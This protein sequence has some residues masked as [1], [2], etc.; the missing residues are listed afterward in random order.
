[1][2]RVINRG[3]ISKILT[4]CTKQAVCRHFFFFFFSLRKLNDTFSNE[5]QTK[6][7]TGKKTDVRQRKEIKPKM[8]ENLATLSS[9]MY[10]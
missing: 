10:I 2:L 1:M 4:T 9:I 3:F 7:L 6:P 5:Y 8:V